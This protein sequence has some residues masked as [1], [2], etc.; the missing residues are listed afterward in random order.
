MDHMDTEQTQQLISLRAE[1]DAMRAEN[2]AF[3]EALLQFFEAHSTVVHTYH[4][5][6]AY[7]TAN[8]ALAKHSA[9]QVQS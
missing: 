8:V 4:L 3:L 6:N 2:A 9:R 7:A 5:D 1:C